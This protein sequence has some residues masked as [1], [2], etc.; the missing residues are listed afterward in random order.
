M[1]LL[2]FL[3]FLCLLLPAGRELAAQNPHED[4]QEIADK[5]YRLTFPK[6]GDNGRW[7]TIRKSYRDFAND[8]LLVFNSLYQEKPVD[9]RTKVTAIIFL[10]N[11]LLLMKSPNHVELLDLKVQTSSYFK[12]VAR[13]QALKSKKQFL[14]HHNEK[15]KNRLELRDA[16]GNLL[17]TVDNVSKFYTTQRGYIY[18][19]T[20]NEKNEFEVLLLRDKT[21]VKVYGTFQKIICLDTDPGEQG[22]MIHEQNP[23]SES[24]EVL[25]LDMGNKMT[26]P[27]KE[28]LP[29]T[30]QKG[31][32]EVIHEGSIYFL[33]LRVNREKE[34]IPLADIRYGNDNKLEQKFSPPVRD[35]CYVWEPKEKR[36]LQTGADQ[37]TKNANIGNDRYF[38]N[39]DP[40]L[41]QDYIKPAPLKID[42]YDRQEDCHTLMDTIP[43]ELHISPGGRYILYEKSDAWHV[44][45]IPTGTKRAINN[46]SLRTPY[47]TENEKVVMFEGEGGL[48]RY[49]LA[50]KDLAQL[51]SFEGYRVS[52]LN[53]TS[54]ITLQ[55][56]NF[57]EKTIR[58]KEPL[59]LKLHDS[60]ENRNAYLL[61][62]N[63]RLDTI[64][65]P[66]TK[67][68]QNLNYNDACTHFSYTEEDYNLPPRLVYKTIGEKGKVIYQSNK[69]DKAI[70]S[71]KQ[72]IISYI[73]NDGIPL[74]GI[75]YYPLHYNPSKKYPMVV[76]IYEKQRHLANRYPYPSYYE[77]LGFNIRLFLENGYFVYLPD[78]LIQGKNGPG[79]DALDCVNSALD[80]LD[81]N[82]L[83]DKHKIGLIGHSFG[84]YE[85]NFIASHSNRFAACVSGSGQSDI[86][87]SYHAFNYN[88]LTPDY[89]R[90]ESGQYRMN[91][92]FSENKKLYLKN[93]PIYNAEKVNAPVLLWTGTEDQNV[94]SDHSMAF[95]NALRRN[96]KNVIA[97]FY[98]GEGHNLQNKDAQFDLTSRILDWFDYFLKDETY[99]EWIRK[100]ISKKGAP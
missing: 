86:L 35:I 18:A 95:Y 79:M 16:G 49:D 91:V 37:L 88:F 48:W 10:D 23:D 78:I 69:T 24:P 63:G 72:E 71:L 36:V 27:L 75:L 94:T 44:Y 41:L 51:N 38:L 22:I 19:I 62:K 67:R 55:G 83:I 96:E 52:I 34:D 3:L 84:G 92:A 1:R 54:R 81:S 33:R 29:I 77:S 82:P 46:S 97:L 57:F 42:I 45:H 20:E 70:L 43:G 93:N 61:W 87:K 28:V 13:M 58:L 66:T 59:V 25:Y 64:I 7:L 31:F 6:M 53:G 32:T 74:K 85:V 68:I 8:T 9:Y 17:N 60:E 47:F 56:I 12:G 11:D 99:V 80:A 30:F 89:R 15:E 5:Y 50:K 40:Y 90:V 21:K 26:Y 2:L 76:H 100:G 73:N 65:P 4:L 98:K 39:F 14:L